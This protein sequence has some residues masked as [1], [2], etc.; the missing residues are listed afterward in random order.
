MW[1][2]AAPI[3]V[4]YFMETRE[5]ADIL[6]LGCLGVNVTPPPDSREGRVWGQAEGLVENAENLQR[7]V[8]DMGPG[9]SMR[10]CGSAVFRPP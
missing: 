1:W 2:R 3:R 10:T 7:S 6:Y 4:D 8:E 9:S 5:Q